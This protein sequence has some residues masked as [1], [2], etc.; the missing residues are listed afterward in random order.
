MQQTASDQN[1]TPSAGST[2]PRTPEGKAVSSENAVRHSL[3]G[4]RFRLLPG[5]SQEEFDQLVSDLK[6]EHNPQTPTESILV[7]AMA[8]SHWNLQRALNLCTEC[9]ESGDDKRLA[10]MMRYQT[11]HE[12][13]FQN[14]LRQL[15]VLQKSRAETEA[16]LPALKLEAVREKLLV[17]KY[18]RLELEQRTLPILLEREHL[19]NRQQRQTDSPQAA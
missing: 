12:R 3:S 16:D 9:L 15:Q 7:V 4:D 18:R 5:E 6:S 10:L 17:T 19:F 1:P 14:A 11:T 13:S 2:G 8:Q